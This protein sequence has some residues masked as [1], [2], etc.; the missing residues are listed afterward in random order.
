MLTYAPNGPKRRYGMLRR[1]APCRYLERSSETRSLKLAAARPTENLRTLL[2]RLSDPSRWTSQPPYRQVHSPT[3]RARRWAVSARFASRIHAVHQRR[4]RALAPRQR[5]AGKQKSPIR[6]HFCEQ[7][8]SPDF[9]AAREFLLEDIRR[10]ETN[11]AFPYA[12]SKRV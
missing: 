4:L 7:R 9:C 12:H 6:C 11:R 2:R 5:T 10:P 8:R 3:L 1:W